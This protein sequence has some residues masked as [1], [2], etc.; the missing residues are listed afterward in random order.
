MGSGFSRTTSES[1]KRRTESGMLA[2][3][4]STLVAA[5]VLSGIAAAAQAPRPW[6]L[7]IQPLQLASD[8]GSSGPQLSV[9]NKCALVSW[10][11]NGENGTV[12]KFAERT[13]AG[14]TQPTTVAS[15]EDWFVTDA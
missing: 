12:L 13:S 3:M 4:R 8:R 10:I 15:G 5:I 14:W 2:P 1:R 7:T 9:S 6:T 11:A